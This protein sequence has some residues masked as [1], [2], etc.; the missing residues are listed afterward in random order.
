M[1]EL[2]DQLVVVAHRRKQHRKPERQP[3]HEEDRANQRDG[4]HRQVGEPQDRREEDQDAQRADGRRTFYQGAC[5]QHVVDRDH[6]VKQQRF[7]GIDGRFGAG[8]D[9]AEENEDAVAEDRERDRANIRRVVR[10]FADMDRRDRAGEQHGLDDHPEIADI[11]AAIARVQFPHHQRPD[12]VALIVEGEP[13]CREAAGARVRV[14]H[15]AT[16]SIKDNA[17]STCCRHVTGCQR[18][19]RSICAKRRGLAGA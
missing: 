19:M 15:A 10:P 6:A 9:R 12:D 16:S 13:E 5:C 18:V 17:V 4:T 8:D 1:D 11:L 3:Q 7:V 14:Q 2:C